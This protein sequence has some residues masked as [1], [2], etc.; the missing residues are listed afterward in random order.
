L[1]LQTF[2]SQG[3]LTLVVIATLQAAHALHG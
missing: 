1:Y 3:G 2:A